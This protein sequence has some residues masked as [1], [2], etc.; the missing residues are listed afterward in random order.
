MR[1]LGIRFECCHRGA[2]AV[3]HCST[4]HLSCSCSASVARCRHWQSL[5][6]GKSPGSGLDRQPVRQCF[7]CCDIVEQKATASEHGPRPVGVYHSHL[8]RTGELLGCSS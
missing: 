4:D 8:L 6:G 7:D 2:L 1:Y 3:G 5:G